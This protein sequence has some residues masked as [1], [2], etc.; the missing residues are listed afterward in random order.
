MRTT[1]AFAMALL[2]CCSAPLAAQ[3]VRIE[4][5]NGKVDLSA[6]NATV[7][8]IL[9]EWGRL[10]GTRIINGD[11]VPGAPVTLELTGAYEREALEILLRGVAG[12]VVGPRNVVSAGAS[13]FDRIM[14]LPTST[15]PRTAQTGQPFSSPG[16]PQPIR[17]PGVVDDT[18][19][20]PGDIV[21]V[22][23]G[24]ARGGLTN[25]RVPPP[26]V[27]QRVGQSLEQNTPG[28]VGAATSA[29]ER[30]QQ[31]VEEDLSDDNGRDDA[32]PLTAPQNPF[33]VAPGS[34]RPG[35]IVPAPTPAQQRPEQEP[36]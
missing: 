5:R 20:D 16:V 13:G 9:Q 8:A 14:I 25:P 28:G 10:G 1:A 33:T 32:R 18:D 31:I 36:R 27:R 2:L 24:A 21:P 12:Y 30:L 4:F 23:P 11:R 35:V 22:Q 19:D 26:I 7:R 34:V 6:Q 15:A 3:S 17:P 29:R